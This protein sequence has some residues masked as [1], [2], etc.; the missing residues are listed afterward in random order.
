MP[1]GGT[2]WSLSLI[3]SDRVSGERRC[4]ASGAG[5]CGCG[6]I[7]GFCLVSQAVARDLSL[8]AQ[9]MPDTLAPAP[10]RAVF[11]SYASQDAEAA[12]GLCGA[13]R[14]A[15]IEVWF[16][17]DSLVGGDAWDAKIRRQIAECALFLPVISA[18]TQAR[19]EGYF[20]LE[21]RNPARAIELLE[22]CA[23]YESGHTNSTFRF[24]LYPVYL[25]G[26]AYLA[27]GRGDPAAKEFQKII[28][29]CGVVGNE[30]IGALAR[31]G[32]GRSYALEGD[33]AKARG[34]YQEFFRL[35]NGADPDLGLLKQ[36]RE[37]FGALR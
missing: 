12:K 1:G 11:L 37:E 35:G 20:C 34:A 5:R 2:G 16:D 21:W 24:A 7:V 15:G 18:N 28:D 17:R 4:V 19:R 8:I 25:R 23:P 22:A 31:L 29:Q 9:P 27:A 10:T 32:L 3:R 14:S 33:A 13:L 6:V 30:P 36:A 26:I